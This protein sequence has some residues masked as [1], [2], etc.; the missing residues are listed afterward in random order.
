LFAIF[1]FLN[2][3]LTEPTGQAAKPEAFFVFKFDSLL[4]N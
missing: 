2:S 1:S 3:S 4:G